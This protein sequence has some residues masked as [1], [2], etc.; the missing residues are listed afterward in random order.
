VQH[1]ISLHSVVVAAKDQV[2]CDLAGDAVILHLK[3][4]VYYGLD[5]VGAFVWKLMQAPMTVAEIQANLV[6]E[7]DVDPGRSEADLLA[8]LQDLAAAGLL[9]VHR[10]GDA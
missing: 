1:I 4:G 10:E 5:A 8:L 3:T 6:K 7:Y 2:S 9:E